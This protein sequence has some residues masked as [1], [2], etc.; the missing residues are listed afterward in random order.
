[1]WSLVW[2]G[3]SEFKISTWELSSS[4]PAVLSLFGWLSGGNKIKGSTWVSQNGEAE[5]DCKKTAVCPMVTSKK[6]G[7]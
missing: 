3:V 4:A 1:M 5:S 6:I 7:P 2:S